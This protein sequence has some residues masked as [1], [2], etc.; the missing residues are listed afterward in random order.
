M[1]SGSLSRCQSSCTSINII[2]MR[3]LDVYD[4]HELHEVQCRILSTRE[5]HIY[6]C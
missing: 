1:A 6:S 5:A 3:I 2:K 4:L